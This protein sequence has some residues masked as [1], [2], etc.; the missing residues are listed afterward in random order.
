[1]HTHDNMRQYVK[2]TRISKLASD[3][4]AGK[5]VKASCNTIC[6]RLP[7][8][9]TLASPWSPAPAAG[10]PSTPHRMRRKSDRT[11]LTRMS[12]YHLPPSIDCPAS[13]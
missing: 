3:I 12:Y 7:L 9:G 11:P 13:V 1:M 5:A 4:R 10:N 6:I 8:Q 2:L